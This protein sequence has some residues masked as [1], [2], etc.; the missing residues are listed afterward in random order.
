MGG[1][2]NY[3]FQISATYSLAKN[4]N[5]ISFFDYDKAQIGHNHIKTYH[6]NIFRNL[7]IG[8]VIYNKIYQEPFFHYNEIPYTKDLKLTGYFQSEKYFLNNKE[9]IKKLF[10]VDNESF[11][12]IKNKYS[13]DLF[14]DSCSLHIR[15]GDYL[16]YPNHHPVC[17]LDYYNMAINLIDNKNILIFSD[18]INWAKENLH[19]KNKNLYFIEN[20]KDYIDLWLMSMCKNNIIANST[21]SWW[22]AWLNKNEDKKVIAPLNWF[23]KAI[24]HNIKDLIPDNWVKI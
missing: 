19:F 4:N 22:G 20:N 11:K 17:S 8:N 1:L 6:N 13:L 10:S 21:F 7:N 23:G 18:D 9:E 12:Y 5:D 15:R 24:N 2:G 14:E 3:L 16:N